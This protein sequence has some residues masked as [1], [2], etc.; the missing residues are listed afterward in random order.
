M[1]AECRSNIG[2]RYCNEIMDEVVADQSYQRCISQRDCMSADCNAVINKV[3]VGCGE[4]GEG[5]GEG[6]EGEGREVKGRGGR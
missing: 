4:G 5:G 3:G 6:G 2:G 1:L